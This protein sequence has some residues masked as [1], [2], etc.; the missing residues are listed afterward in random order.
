MTEQINDF[1][2]NWLSKAD[3]Y[4]DK[5]LEN[6]FDRFIS[7]YVV[8]NVLYMEIVKECYLSNGKKQ[9]FKDDIAATDYVVQYVG[10]KSFIENLFNDEQSKTDLDIICDMINENLFYINIDWLGYRKQ[11]LDSKLLSSLYSKNKGTKAKAILSLLYRIR[12]NIIHGHKDFTERQENL[13]IPVNNLLRKTVE[14]VYNKILN[15]N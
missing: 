9:K 2:N 5:S 12:C 13:L 1:Y 3:S 14:I 8:Y 4:N 7:L 10:S 15:K 6:L 11:K